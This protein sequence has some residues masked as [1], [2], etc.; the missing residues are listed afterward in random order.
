[1]VHSCHCIEG[2]VQ[3]V[4]CSAEVEADVSLHDEGLGDAFYAAYNTSTA[5]R[6]IGAWD[7]SCAM[8][9]Q[10]APFGLLALQQ[11]CVAG[12]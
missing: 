4:A 12:M 1:M 6:C 10:I 7:P 3:A 11:G 9:W 8:T 5:R 2:R